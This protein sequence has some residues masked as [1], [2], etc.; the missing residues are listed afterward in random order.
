MYVKVRVR[1]GAKRE[2][3]E[4]LKGDRFAISVKEPAERNQANKRVVEL[5]AAHFK[6]SP[7]KIRIKSGHHS[8]SKILS[9]L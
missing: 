1:T 4:Q 9:V 3:V 6:I 8:P 7:A 5:I 2:S